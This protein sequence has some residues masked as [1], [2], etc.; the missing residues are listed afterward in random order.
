MVIA[1][2]TSS[3]V[4]CGQKKENKPPEFKN[5][6]IPTPT[7]STIP[8]PPPAQP[9]PI[10][11]PAK[12][13]DDKNKPAESDNKSKKDK[14]SL[15]C[16]FLCDESNKDSKNKKESNSSPSKTSSNPGS[17]SGSSSGGSGS[18]SGSQSTSS[19]S[20]PNT[21]TT[22][23]AEQA[24]KELQYLKDKNTRLIQ[25]SSIYA[26]IANDE[27]KQRL[28]LMRESNSVEQRYTDLLTASA[29]SNVTF[30]RP[31]EVDI[32]HVNIVLKSTD[33]QSD[34]ATE[35]KFVGRCSDGT[36]KEARNS[37]Y[38]RPR[39]EAKFQ[40][41]D[42]DTAQ[43]ESSNSN[44][45]TCETFLFTT[46]IPKN[47]SLNK[48]SKV[49]FTN[50]AVILRDFQFQIKNAHFA[51]LYDTTPLPGKS[52]VEFYN[53]LN[54]STKIGLENFSNAYRLKSTKMHS[55][56]VIEGVTVA[57][58]T[59]VGTDLNI[60]PSTAYWYKVDPQNPLQGV[61]SYQTCQTARNSQMNEK[62]IEIANQIQEIKVL[63]N[64]GYGEVKL[65]M[66][67][68]N[69]EKAASDLVNFVILNNPKPVRTD[70]SY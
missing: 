51:N 3:I 30:S 31:T 2:M 63:E 29:I 37:N 49:T 24:E 70:F 56:E 1:L 69:P 8:Q 28:I 23:N 10:P 53:L 42:A 16:K 20:D 48:N 22:S 50:I 47:N 54:S 55:A 7:S 36:M 65:Q 33:Q 4:A 12:P 34:S 40:C 68:A 26:N 27:L 15:V 57:E 25:N 45:K 17:K 44:W 6:S 39:A 5:E 35:L 67:F 11:T 21:A 9:T 14:G 62:V 61:E 46:R 38:N 32:C 58:M 60:V 64:L 66:L 52:Y 13:V 19:D 18:G 41:M 43:F 59:M